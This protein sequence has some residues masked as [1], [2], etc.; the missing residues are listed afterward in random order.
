MGS[1]LEIWLKTNVPNALLATVDT[2]NQAIEMLK[3]GHVNAV[4]VGEAQGPAFCAQNPDLSYTII[5][6]AEKG[7]GI[8]LKKGS[9]L[10]GAINSAL[11]K[12]KAKGELDRLK[13]KWVG[14]ER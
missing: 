9:A 14:G 6:S 1:T 3:A 7:S 11:K 8:L 12:L 13:K 4:L 2:N 5:A 10:R